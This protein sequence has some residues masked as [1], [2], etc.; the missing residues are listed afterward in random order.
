MGFNHLSIAFTILILAFHKNEYCLCV[1]TARNTTNFDVNPFIL[2]NA[3]DA[4]K[5][6]VN[7][8][9]SVGKDFRPWLTFFYLNYHSSFLLYTYI[10][11]G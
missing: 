8:V 4:N 5:E 6:I 9:N 10:T 3:K 1:T 11:N 2:V 7:I